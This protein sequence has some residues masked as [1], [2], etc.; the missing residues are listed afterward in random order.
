ARHYPNLKLMSLPL[1]NR[2]DFA[3]WIGRQRPGYIVLGAFS[4]SLFSQLFKKSFA[5]RVIHDIRMP[6]F[7]SHK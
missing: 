2:N 1:V 3:D 7:I 6:I 5:N 4:R